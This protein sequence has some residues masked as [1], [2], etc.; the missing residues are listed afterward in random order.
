MRHWLILAAVLPIAVALPS[1][2]CHVADPVSV[3]TEAMAS[4]ECL[5]MSEAFSR[6][7]SLVKKGLTRAAAVAKM[8]DVARR[9][10]VDVRP[11]RSS[12]A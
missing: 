4:R 11:M 7:V 10:S 8:L 3:V 9:R 1:V 5:T 6:R 12:A 2:S